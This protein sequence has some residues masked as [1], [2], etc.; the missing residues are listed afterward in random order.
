MKSQI[1]KGCLSTRIRRRALR[2]T[3]SLKDL[4]DTAR[5]Y[6][7]AE[8]QAS[9]METSSMPAVNVESQS[10]NKLSSQNKFRKN[11]QVTEIPRNHENVTFVGE[12]T[13]IPMY[14]QL[15]IR[16]VDIATKLVILRNVVIKG[17]V[18]QNLNRLEPSNQK[19]RLNNHMNQ[20]TQ[21]NQTPVTNIYSRSE[22]QRLLPV[23]WE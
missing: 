4:L 1:I 2:E 19:S 23:P 17:N 14:V 7:L 22:T 11:H 13:H 9:G 10:V 5:S 6:E 12:S 3:L 8:Y 18:T 20:N 21:L 15:K 16:T